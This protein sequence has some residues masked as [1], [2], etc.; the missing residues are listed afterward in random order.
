MVPMTIE[1]VLRVLDAHKGT[2]FASMTSR[3]KKLPGEGGL[4]KFKRGDKTVACPFTEGI[5]HWMKQRIILGAS[6]AGMVN[7]QRGRELDT[8][9]QSLPPPPKFVKDAQPF[10][11]EEFLAEK[12]WKGKGVRDEV[13][14]RLVAKHSESG[15]RYLVYR[16]GSD[17][18]GKP[19]PIV[20]EYY[21][22]STGRLLDFDLDVKDFYKPQSEQ[23][24]GQMTEKWIPWQTVKL[25]NIIEICYGGETYQMA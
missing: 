21:D 16:P 6:Y 3:T 8:Y 1:N 4:N 20:S 2:I 11:A 10:E 15:Q 24:K 19:E 22:I 13:Y 14:P 23:P 25:E 12:L 5:E 9:V 17:E 7:N 18:V